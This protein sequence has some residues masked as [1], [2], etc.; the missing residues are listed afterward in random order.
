MTDEARAFARFCNTGIYA[1][2]SEDRDG[3][4]ENVNIQIA[5]D[6][7]YADDQAWPVVGIFKDNDISASKYS[8]KPREDYDRL[9]AAIKR[10][11]INIVLITEMPRLYRRLEEL[12]DLIK[13]AETTALRRIQTTEGISY[14]LS[15]A[16]GIH[17]AI[18][19]VNNAM[20]EAA[21]TSKRVKRKQ[22]A[23]AKDGKFHGGG[24]PY[25]YEKDGVTVCEA[26]AEIIR[27]CARRMIVGETMAD[28]VR[29]LSDR[30]VKT[31]NGSEWRMENL[32]RTL[33]R[34]RNIGVCEYN[35]A[36]Y[37]AVWPAIL[38][39]E[40][41]EQ[42]DAIRLSKA[43]KWAKGSTGARKYLLTG[44]C[45]CGK[46]GGKM[47]GNGETEEA[48][49]TETR[50]YACRLKDNHGRPLGCGGVSR[51]AEPVEELVTLA[52]IKALSNP[53]VALILAPKKNE[54]RIRVLVTDYEQRKSKLDQLV[55]DYAT[56]FLNREQYGKARAVAETAL[57]QTRDEL[58]KL[59]DVAALARVPAGV[60]IEEA[61]KSA[62]L[63]WRRTMV[64][65]VVE[66]V[67]IHPGQSGARMW[68]G[69]RFNPDLIEI[70]WK[71]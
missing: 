35:G 65:L 20:L 40:Q 58:T 64:R 25:G 38:T 52:V 18:N 29:D 2:L 66:K 55:G 67:T 30:G 41:W 16:E 21:R 60:T 1:R 53:R 42:M 14:E 13:L 15:T 11:E 57:D 33:T 24:R 54:K 26:E 59:Q 9:V 61:W 12:L 4:S 68:H 50:R 17:A 45:T 70:E 23:R 62:A 28:I 34:K 71:V 22:A 6:Q 48:T 56:G 39:R 31:G 49:G 5:E 37:P 69:Y 47:N 8:T 63:G 10:N 46:C 3:L 43:W 36:E 32:Q 19:A 44:F 27:E 7:A 51:L